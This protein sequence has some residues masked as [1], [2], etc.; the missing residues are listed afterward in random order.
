M[1]NR[2]KRLT[3]VYDYVRRHYPIHTQGDFAQ[4]VGYSRPVISSALNGN[5]EYL[6][7][8]FFTN[9]CNAFP[10]VFN[11]DYLLHGAGNLLTPREDSYQSIREDY[12]PSV[13]KEPDTLPSLPQWADTLISILSTQIKENEALNR[14]LRQ[15]ITEVN[16]LRTDLQK[17]IEKFTPKS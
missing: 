12:F 15:S 1:N 14:E 11:L 17:L 7:D 16:A 2:K 6:S 4:V 5:E 10:N 9:I 13:A 8:K 3:E